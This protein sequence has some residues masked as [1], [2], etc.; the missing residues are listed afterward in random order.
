MGLTEKGL[1]LIELIISLAVIAI[2]VSLLYSVFFVTL[3]TFGFGERQ[4]DVVASAGWAIETMVKEIRQARAIYNIEEI[5][6]FYTTDIELLTDKGLEWVRFYVDG[7]RLLRANLTGFSP[8]KGKPLAE[9]VKDFRVEYYNRNNIKI[10]DPVTNKSDVR[11]ILFS[12]EVEKVSKTSG[13]TQDVVLKARVR[14]RG[15]N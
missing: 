3:H 8:G 13:G 4:R 14:P 2:I 6:G 9:N 1:T 11:L 5:S 7:S 15:I 12:L 10:S